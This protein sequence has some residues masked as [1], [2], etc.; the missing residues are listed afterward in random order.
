MDLILDILIPKNSFNM[1]NLDEIF[2]E[3]GGEKF[4][5][6]PK[7]YQFQ[8]KVFFHENTEMSYYKNILGDIQDVYDYVA[9]TLEGKSLSELE[10]MVNNNDF[11]EYRSELISLFY[12]LYNLIDTFCIIKFLNEGDIDNKYILANANEA[13][14]VFINSLDWNSP[15]GIVISKKANCTKGCSASY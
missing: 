6:N 1:L 12:E 3:W 5:Q 15:K 4:S 2:V 8:S 14:D 7:K 10:F 9:L 11:R 13:V